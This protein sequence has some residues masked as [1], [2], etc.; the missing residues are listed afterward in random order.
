M[1]KCFENGQSD[2]EIIYEK[3]QFSIL[4]LFKK[5]PSWGFTDEFSG[6]EYKLRD[7]RY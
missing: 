5:C 2:R 1:A 3:H 7:L 4:F 6:Q